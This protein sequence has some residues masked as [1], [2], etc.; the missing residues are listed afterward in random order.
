M[1]SWWYYFAS[2]LSPAEVKYVK[3]YAKAL[4][5]IEGTV[6]HGGGKS[7]VRKVM[8]NSVIKWIRR[9]HQ[10]QWLFDRISLSALR[11][12]MDCFHFDLPNAPYLNYDS[13]Q[14]TEYSSKGEQH[15]DWHTDNNWLTNWPE[16][17]DRKISCVVQLTDPSQYEGGKLELEGCSIPEGKF[18]NAGDMI[19]FPSFLKHR[20]TPVTKGKR[21]SLVTW[22]TG[23]RFR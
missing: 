13:L 19:L 15:Y 21:Q 16:T 8:R 14:F 5:S 3:D 12:N 7:V 20:V 18:Q 23:P 11:A 6:G 22:I 9:D 4:P 10:I 1:K 17:H 2:H